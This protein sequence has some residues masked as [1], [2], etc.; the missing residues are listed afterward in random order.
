MLTPKKI[1]Y[2]NNLLYLS[3]ME[4][5]HELTQ[6]LLSQGYPK[7]FYDLPHKL[8]RNLSYDDQNKIFISYSNACGMAIQELIINHKNDAL[9]YYLTHLF[10]HNKHKHLTKSLK[11][12]IGLC[13]LSDNDIAFQ[14]F[15]QIFGYTTVTHNDFLQWY[16][17]QISK[18]NRSQ[19]YKYSMYKKIEDMGL[20]WNEFND[21]LPRSV[22]FINKPSDFDYFYRKR[23][24]S[25]TENAD[26]QIRKELLKCIDKILLN[27]YKIEDNINSELLEHILAKK[28]LNKIDRNSS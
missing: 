9:D 24:N 6:T 20:N 2:N 17:L 10:E 12:Y 21:C 22:R 19:K 28:E 18:S 27:G 11:Y 13:F 4:S 5:N 14:L 23:K 7:N 26:Q 8:K 25:I 3:L 16:I 1:S 15:A